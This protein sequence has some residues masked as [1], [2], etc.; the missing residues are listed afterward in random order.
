MV[1]VK[2]NSKMVGLHS[3]I[4]LSILKVNDINTIIKRQRLANLIKTRQTIW[5]LQKA[6]FKYKQKYS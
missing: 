5:Y 3:T 2:K 1:Q 4:F 6:H